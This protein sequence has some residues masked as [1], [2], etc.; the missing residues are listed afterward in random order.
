MLKL[1]SADIVEDV[2]APLL[3]DTEWIIVDMARK[4]GPRSLNPSGF[5]AGVSRHVLGIPIPRNLANRTLEALRC[6][7]VRAWYWDVIRSDDIRMLVDA[8]YSQAQ[9]MEVLAHVAAHRGFSPTVQEE[10]A[11][12]ERQASRS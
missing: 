5:W 1:R 11:C 3:N 9:A 2:P 6:F 10:T 12:F 8:G 4:D 7:A